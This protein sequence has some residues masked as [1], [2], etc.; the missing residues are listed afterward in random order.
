MFKCNKNTSILMIDAPSLVKTL[1]L[2]NAHQYY[3]PLQV[4]FNLFNLF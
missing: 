2:D 1:T 3:R 4:Q